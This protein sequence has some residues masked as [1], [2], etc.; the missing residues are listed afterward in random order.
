[1]HGTG[2]PGAAPRP[3]PWQADRG[4]RFEED[5]AR[6]NPFPRDHVNMLGCYSFSLPELPDVLRPL[7]PAYA[8][9]AS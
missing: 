2:W 1:M 7:R 4:H 5:V 3:V 6:L 8:D 9:D